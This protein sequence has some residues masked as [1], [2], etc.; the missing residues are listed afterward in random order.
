MVRTLRVGLAA[1]SLLLV[2][3]MPT[4]HAEDQ[5]DS[6][7]KP[8]AAEAQSLFQKWQDQSRLN[9]KIPGGALRSL[10][11]AASNF[12]KYN[13]ED[14]RAAPLSELH[15]RMDVSRDWT[16]QEAVSLLNDV[17]DVYA[18]LPKWAEDISRF[19][20][21]DAIR[22]GEPLPAE[23]R[24]SPWGEAHPNGLRVAWRLDPQQSEHPLGTALKSRILYHN[25]GEKSVFF[26]VV[27]WNQSGS[28]EARDA[29]GD[30]IR[31]TSTEW[32]T[33]GQV[34]A[35][36]LDP[37]EF[38][39]VMGAGIGVGEHSDDDEIDLKV[40]VGSWIHADAGDVVTFTPAPI[41]TS[42]D[43]GRMREVDD[44]IWWLSFI[45]DRLNRDAPLPDDAAERE[46]ILDG[47]I[48][49][50][51]GTSP[52]QQ[53]LKTFV[54]DESPD[55]MESLAKRLSQRDGTTSVAG[56][57]KSGETTFRVTAAD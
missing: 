4:G 32:T 16:P 29:N 5:E 14:E 19:T 30:E 31:I 1:V 20:I 10:A 44:S 51:F 6:T 17:T 54:E 38:T 22:T 41:T 24:D 37:G 26:R 21:S 23:L 56:T 11:A 27:S 28:H 53:E 8:K 46:R 50:L 55:A 34:M 15:K 3:G 39:E 25:T 7:L 13:P 49:D 48:Q 33:I 9:G 43:D 40:R 57:L 52:T 2:L 36:R 18:S 45:T 42:G 12:M 35:C 47:V